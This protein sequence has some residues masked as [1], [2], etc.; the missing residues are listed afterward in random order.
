M[1]VNHLRDELSERIQLDGRSLVHDQETNVAPPAAFVKGVL[2]M[3]ERF[4]A[5]VSNAMRGEKRRRRGCGR[6]LRIF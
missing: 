5:V 3:R 4:A 2:D 1:S 6:R